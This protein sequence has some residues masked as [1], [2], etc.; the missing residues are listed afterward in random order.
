M[1]W[2]SFM[3]S[4]KTKQNEKYIIFRRDYENQLRRIEPKVVEI[5]N[6]K[7]VNYLL[8]DIKNIIIPIKNSQKYQKYYDF[9]I[10]KFFNEE[11]IKYE[12]INT[13]MYNAIKN[14]LEN[15]T[16]EPYNIKK[17]LIENHFIDV[18]LEKNS[19]NIISNLFMNNKQ[20]IKS[21]FLNTICGNAG[22]CLTFG[23]E[24]NTINEYFNYFNDFKYIEYPVTHIGE[25][26][27]NGFVLKINYNR[28]NYK[29]TTIL[30]SINIDDNGDNLYYEYVVGL[31]INKLNKFY[32][33]FLETYNLFTYYN[34]SQKDILKNTPVIDSTTSTFSEGI[35]IYYPKTLNPSQLLKLSCEKRN[36]ICILLQYINVKKSFKY[37]LPNRNFVFME[38][39][40]IL[41]QIY[42][43]LYYLKE[44]FTHYDLHLENILL[45]E[46][47]DQYIEFV[48]HLIDGTEIHFKTSYIAKIIDYGRCYF[49]DVEN[50]MNSKLFFENICK[51]EMCT[52][53]TQP[54][55]H[56]TNEEEQ[57]KLNCGID[58]GY[59]NLNFGYRW[60]TYKKNESQDL[61]LLDIMKLFVFNKINLVEYSEIS[62]DLKNLLNKVVFNETYNTNE[63]LLDGSTEVDP[64]IYNLTDVYLALINQLNKPLQISMNNTEYSNK[65]KIGELHIY[66]DKSKEMEFE[67]NQTKWQYP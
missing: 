7:N 12:T 3:K 10:Q 20:K 53:Q 56:S 13:K 40:Y 1:N 66:C 21:I 30:K 26:S 25:S 29:V 48:Y 16:K 49:N 57:K 44:T 50:N 36:L 35:N 2:P 34:I 64:K 45:F 59:D 31:F 11:Y 39:L 17:I 51:E 5:L 67:T 46:L 28:N 15:I 22:F 8:N 4:T 38:L 6:N 32:S 47:T 42:I 60:Y 52:D 41:A 63:I 18:D 58:K 14:I 65:T 33:C 61:R 24:T 62:Q 27:L 23:K 54:N 37:Y 19:A 9:L 43:V 55:I